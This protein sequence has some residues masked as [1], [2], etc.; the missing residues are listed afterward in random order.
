MPLAAVLTLEALEDGQI[1]QDSRAAVRRFWYRYLP[2]AAFELPGQQAPL[3][4]SPLMGDRGALAGQAETG[5]PAWMRVT[6][7]T[8]E[9]T[10][11]LRGEALPNLPRQVQAAGLAW[12]VTGT[13]TDNAKH[14]WAGQCSY[15]H[16]VDRHLIN[17]RA[18]RS[19][20]ITFGNPVSFQRSQ[21]SS[22]FPTP[23][24]LVESWIGRWETFGPVAL[25][26]GLSKAVDRKMRIHAN[27]LESCTL[28]GSKRLGCQG[29]LDLQAQGM[30]NALRA[31]FDM[32][33]AF[34]CFAGSGFENGGLTQA[35]PPDSP[36]K[37]GNP[38]GNWWFGGAQS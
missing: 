30:K 12:Q 35:G 14:P 19:W 29:Q 31:G 9:L 36:P 2:A 32:L 33:A 27:G 23:K 26:L 20:R 25:P 13:F 7:L 3:T 21:Y 28:L 8:D 11:A 38:E 18:P 10:E 15:Q 22:P 5:T 4:F 34:A 16:L 6:A 17:I 1:Y 24:T 37:T